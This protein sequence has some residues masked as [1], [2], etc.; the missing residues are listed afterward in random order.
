MRKKWLVVGGVGLV[1]L[2]LLAATLF[3][4]RV[5]GGPC[6]RLVKSA[7]SNKPQDSYGLL[8]G[9]LQGEVSEDAWKQQ[10]EFWFS[11]YSTD[12]STSY[13]LE[14]TKPRINPDTN[15]ETQQEQYLITGASGSYRGVCNLDT[16]GKVDSY[17]SISTL[18]L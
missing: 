18:Q 13:K 8:S 2:V 1:V 3:F 10:I 5:Q 16:S 9:R 4:N 7:I 6:E 14:Q 17:S 15:E 12:D 11:Q